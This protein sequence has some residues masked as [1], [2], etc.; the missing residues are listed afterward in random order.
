MVQ[1]NCWRNKYS[2]LPVTSSGEDFSIKNQNKWITLLNSSLTDLIFT[3]PMASRSCFFNHA[4]INGIISITQPLHAKQNKISCT[5][6]MWIFVCSFFFF[7]F[8]GLIFFSTY[9]AIALQSRISK[10]RS[11]N[12]IVSTYFVF[13]LTYCFQYSNKQQC[14]I[15]SSSAFTHYTIADC[16]CHWVTLNQFF[17]SA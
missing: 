6:F 8:L 11:S 7:F 17:S 3:S 9:V 1:I 14:L 2:P 13:L 15:I 5:L 4:Q 12:I 16:H 10:Q